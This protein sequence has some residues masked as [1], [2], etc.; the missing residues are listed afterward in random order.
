MANNSI[1]AA[2]ERM[3]QHVM[4]IANGKAPTENGQYTVTTA[5]DGSAYTATVP[6]VTALTAGASFIMIPHVVSAT[7]TPTLNVNGLGA[8]NIKRR[9]SNL[10]TSLQ[11]GYSNTWL[12]KG[13]PFRVTY[14]GTAW[15]VEG[16][17][18]PAAADMYGLNASI[19]ELNYC[20]GVTS[21]IQEQLDELSNAIVDTPF[22]SSN[23]LTWAG[24]AEGL[25]VIDTNYYKMSDI[26]PT[27]EQLQNISKIFVSTTGAWGEPLSNLEIVDNGGYYSI[28]GYDTQN[29]KFSDY[30]RVYYEGD[31]TG[32]YFYYYRPNADS[33]LAYCVDSVTFNDYVFTTLKEDALPATGVEAGSYGGYKAKNGDTGTYNI[34]SITVDKSGRITEVTNQQINTVST[35]R[36]MDPGLVTYNMLMRIKTHAQTCTG[37]STTAHLSYVNLEDVKEVISNGLTILPQIINVLVRVKYD[38]KGSVMWVLPDKYTTTCYRGGTGMLTTQVTVYPPEEYFNSYNQDADGKYTYDVQVIYGTG[39]RDTDGSV[40]LM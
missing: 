21:P 17:E 16:H 36:P 31:A 33:G 32:I 27:Y 18:K 3:W 15:I 40:N 9:L 1:K 34:P 7:T 2:F 12:A 8:K 24:S 26:V 11:N 19:T 29:Y 10:S 14:D 38:S 20:D 5:G 28:S 22:D 25:E 37:V 4:L 6:G 30:V 39:T 13:K 23:T 35:D